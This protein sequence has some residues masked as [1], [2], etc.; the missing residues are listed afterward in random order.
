MLCAM[1]FKNRL[2]CL[3]LEGTITTK[4][5]QFQRSKEFQWSLQLQFVI[6]IYPW[7]CR[8]IRDQEINGNRLN[9][10]KLPTYRCVYLLLF[11][12]SVAIQKFLTLN[13]VFKTWLETTLNICSSSSDYLV[14]IS[15]KWFWIRHLYS[16]FYNISFITD[17]LD[18]VA[19]KV[20]YGSRHFLH[21]YHNVWFGKN[22]QQR[23]HCRYESDNLQT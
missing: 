22:I 2:V 16:L 14:N 13:N 23:I 10:F 11:D 15:N 6:G 17:T 9:A 1:E 3:F 18:V 4:M 12:H 19:V 21:P 7:I 8:I 5:F 20:I